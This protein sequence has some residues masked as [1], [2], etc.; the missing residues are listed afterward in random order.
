MGNDQIE[1][2]VRA[3]CY[4]DS[5]LVNVDFDETPHGTRNRKYPPTQ[6]VQRFNYCIAFSLSVFTKQ[7]RIKF[8]EEYRL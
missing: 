5:H 6:C 3:R 7:F 1:G 4:G 8:N 2:T